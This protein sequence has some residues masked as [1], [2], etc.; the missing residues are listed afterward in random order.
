MVGIS[1]NLTLPIRYNTIKNTAPN[2]DSI[3]GSYNAEL[4][5]ATSRDGLGNNDNW[6][7]NSGD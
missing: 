4:K 6:W 3:D 7:Q 2:F 5:L 1:S